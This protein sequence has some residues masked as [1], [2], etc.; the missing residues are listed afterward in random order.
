[1]LLADYPLTRV[2][3]DAMWTYM[4]HKGE[5]ADLPKKADRGSSW[6]G[7]AIDIDTRLR[8]GRA[9]GKNVHKVA[10]TTMSQIKDRCNAIVPPAIASDGCD[11]YPEAMLETSGKVLEYCG[12]G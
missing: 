2:Q 10:M 8:V 12:R 11:S 4:V 5:K 6:R 3:L 7:A 9:I 1:L